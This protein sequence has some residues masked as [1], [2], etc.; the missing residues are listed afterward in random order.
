MRIALLLLSAGLVCA[1]DYDL[2]LKGGHVI[3]PKNKISATRDVAI[4]NGRIAAVEADIPATK[5]LRT[6]DVSGLYVTPGLVDLHVH[7]YAG[8]GTQYTGPSSVRPDDH[9]FRSGVTTVVD[10][11]SS[12]WRN[13]EDFKKL[14]IDNARTRVL[15]LLNIVGA[16]M[17]GAD[18]QNLKDMDPAKAAEMAAK[19]KDLIVGFKS[20][21]YAGP[22]WTPVENA[23]KAGEIAG[24]PIMVDFG[25]FRPERPF[26]DLVTK[27][28]RPGDMYTHT[29]LSSVPML[30][31][32]GKVRP[33]LFEARKRGVL[34]DAGHGGGSFL[35]RQAVPAIQQGFVPDSIS[36]DLH[37]G[38]MNG[39]M[40]TMLTTMSKFV[41]MGM[42]LDD[43]I[44]RSTWNPARQIKREDLGHLSVGATADIAVLRLAKGDFGFVD[45][46]GARMQGTQKL[47]GEL[48]THD[49][50]VVWD[51]N[52][53][54]RD[55]WKK[56]GKYGA[57][58]DTRWDGIVRPE[59]RANRAH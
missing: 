41:N 19:H 44:L 54:T 55:D 32:A 53:R 52:G 6:V 49:G 16:G 22:E 36:T 17:G 5:A 24:L 8:T 13:F 23:V 40:Q 3:D 33:F 10:A 51:M 29:Y 2:L 20:A 38:S 21:H 50:K 25:R 18:E 46:N 11:G 12:G 9:T 4:K 56:L 35:F 39:A 14:I 48:T 57:Q 37:I 47:E 34:F 59:N 7:V 43:V 30:D 15:A 45:V 27:K 28:L 26:E 31:D 58:G 42:T 1:Q